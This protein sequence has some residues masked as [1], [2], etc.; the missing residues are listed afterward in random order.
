MTDEPREEP[1]GLKIGLV[2]A[3]GAV[4][5][6]LLETLEH[7]P[8]AVAE[9]RLIARASSSPSSIEVGGES[10]RVLPLPEQAGRSALFENL[11]LVIFAAPAS[12]TRAWIPHVIAQGVAALDIGGGLYPDLPL[13]VPTVSL[14][15]LAQVAKTRVVSTPSAPAVLLS[16]VLAPFQD[17]GIIGVTGTVMLSASSLGRRG[18]AEL[19]QQV[20]SL[21]NSGEA[22]RVVFPK[23]LAFDLDAQLGGTEHGWSDGELRLS[24]ELAQVL[25]SDPRRFRLTQVLVPIFAGMAV[26][27]H[28]Q[29]EHNEGLEEIARRLEEAAFVKLADPVPGPRVL[30]GQPQ[31]YVGRLREDPLGDGFHVLA[32]AD[33]LRFGA[34][35]NAMAAIL[36][37]RA[38]G[39]L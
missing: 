18:S 1:R 26:Q 21:F 36:S 39:L 38:K 32:V 16:S 34:S 15:P 24:G 7:G 5:S 28:V 19:S 31:A 35:A 20:I 6:D 10:C 23:G 33:N 17:L 8:I 2:G 14:E 4:G 29:L 12:I 27:L 37:M 30:V 13:L 11:D 9:W 25:E 3:T 22:Q